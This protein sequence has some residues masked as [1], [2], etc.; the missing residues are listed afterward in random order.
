MQRTLSGVY[1]Q[2]TGRGLAELLRS[3][4]QELEHMIGRATALAGGLRRRDE[5]PFVICH[6]D[7][8]K[9][10]ILSGPEGEVYAV[11]WD[12]LKLAPKECDLMFIGGNIGGAA[13]E[14]ASFYTGYGETRVDPA[15]L[16]YYRYERIVADVAAFSQEV[17]EQPEPTEEECDEIVR[18]VAANFMPGNE[19][20]AA[21]HTDERCG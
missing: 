13:V 10:N 20:E 7:L 8:H 14:E 5:E 2:G 11:D 1:D 21:R 9:W 16:A 4:K 3:R 19:L 12:S 15:A 17:W 18:L 6:A